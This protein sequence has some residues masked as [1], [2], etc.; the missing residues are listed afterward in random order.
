MGLKEGQRQ[1]ERER[2]A[3]A[4]YTSTSMSAANDNLNAT[5]T[6]RRM[7]YHRNGAR[8][9]RDEASHAKVIVQCRHLIAVVAPVTSMWSVGHDSKPSKLLRPALIR[10]SVNASRTSVLAS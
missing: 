2:K 9:V 6:E 1:L 3:A 7:S 8:V 5:E 10:G 4:G